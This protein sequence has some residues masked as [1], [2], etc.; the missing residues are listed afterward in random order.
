MSRIGYIIDSTTLL[1]SKFDSLPVEIVQLNVNTPSTTYKEK[2]LTDQQTV[3]LE[4]DEKTIKSSSPSPND[5]LDAYNKLFSEGCTE[6]ICIPLSQG[7]SGTY[8]VAH[9]AKDTLEN[10]LGE[11][12]HILDALCCNY[13]ITNVFNACYEDILNQDKSVEFMIDKMNNLLKNNTTLFTIYDLRHL[14]RGG[15]LSRLSCAIGIVLKIKPIVK[16]IDG[17]LVLYK[18]FSNVNKIR[19][20]FIET[21]DEYSHKYKDVYLRI[22][23]LKLGKE[24][25]EFFKEIQEKYSNIHITCGDKIGPVFTVHLGDIGLGITI[26]GQN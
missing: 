15:R 17:K 1:D 6:I 25:D 14:F 4:K 13:A 20:L 11:H 23:H 12:V 9:I 2:D 26:T 21:I 10:D 19:Q 24:F 18:K 7:L 5:F 8:Q 3:Q 22:I 16:V